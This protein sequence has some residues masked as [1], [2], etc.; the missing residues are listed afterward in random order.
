MA[1][2]FTTTTVDLYPPAAPTTDS[3]GDEVRAFDDPVTG[4]P[5][6]VEPDGTDKRR[7]EPGH[8]HVTGRYRVFLNLGVTITADYRIRWGGIDLELDGEPQRR[9]SPFGGS[10]IEV[11]AYQP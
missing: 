1:L 7:G 8:E 3:F 9:P 11:R 4:V 2:P 6:V 10:H 5:A